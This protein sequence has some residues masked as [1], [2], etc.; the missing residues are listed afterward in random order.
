VFELNGEPH[1]TW[2]I[3]T[4]ELPEVARVAIVQLGESL[5]RG[6]HQARMLALDDA[7][8]TLAV[9][10]VIVRGTNTAATSQVDGNVQMQRAVTLMVGNVESLCHS[11]QAHSELM[12]KGYQE[13]LSQNL[14]LTETLQGLVAAKSEQSASAEERLARSRRMDQMFERFLPMLELGFGILAAEVERRY[15]DKNKLPAAP[16]SAPPSA[17]PV[18]P[19]VAPATPPAPPEVVDLD[20]HR[21]MGGSA[22]RCGKPS[23]PVPSP[24]RNRHVKKTPAPKRSR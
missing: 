13:S 9:L 20:A 15:S 18:A 24:I 8:Q 1:A 21:S 22:V 2:S 10:P 5:P 17:P 12:S 6:N 14:M 4:K 11:M 23:K 16:P 7:G 3:D 19:S